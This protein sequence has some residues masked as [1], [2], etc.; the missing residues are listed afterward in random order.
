M[1]TTRVFKSGNSQ[2]VRLPR[3][4]QFDVDEVEILRRGEEIVLRK[5]AVSL[6]EAFELLA[7]MPDDFMSEGRHNLPPQARD[8]L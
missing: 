6:A 8:E 4:F 3:D 2:A 5:K 1:A 7:A